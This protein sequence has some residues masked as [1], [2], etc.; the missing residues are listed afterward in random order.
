MTKKEQIQHAAQELFWKHGFKRVSVEEI[1]K[2]SHVSRK[3][4]YSYF[5]NKNAL[6]IFILT[7]FN[8]ELL[9]VYNDII[10]SE[11]SFKEKLSKLLK[12]KFESS[13]SFSKEF[14]AD[15]FN[16]E[17][18]DILAYF[19][20]VAEESMQ[21]TKNFFLKGQESGEINSNLNIDYLMWMMQKQLELIKSPELLSMFPD[22]ESM[23]RQ[24]TES[25]IYGIMPPK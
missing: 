25:V 24:I 19:T 2:K 8:K 15:F 5:E 17:A 18:A 16:P 22:A 14:I 3:T 21:M 6:V 10:E 1:S 7:V 12:L 9:C 20:Q 13:E 23:T 11:L 4:F